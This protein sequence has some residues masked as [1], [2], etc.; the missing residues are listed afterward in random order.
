[1][2]LYEVLGL[3]ERGTGAT[4]EEITKAYR[5]AALKA[6][7]DKGGSK[8]KWERL[9][10]A[11]E[12]LS[13]KRLRVIYDTQGLEAAERELKGE[14]N[15][16]PA[17]A[18]QFFQA[19]MQQHSQPQRSVTPVSVSLKQ[20]YLAEPIDV[21]GAGDK[22]LRITLDNLNPFG[23]GN[24]VF[25][26][27]GQTTIQLCLL[28]HSFL[29][30][31]PRHLVFVQKIDICE[32]L[33]GFSVRFELP[34]NEKTAVSFEYKEKVVGPRTEMELPANEKQKVR[35]GWKF[36]IRFDVVFAAAEN[37]AWKSEKDRQEAKGLLERLLGK[38]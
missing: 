17:W 19:F 15:K 20:I 6:H 1:M 3:K 22:K 33:T 2:S 25:Y 21:E 9:A 38:R 23:A 12:I 30:A 26:T 34:D 27:V 14:N 28:P 10:R 4:D 37:K 16:G 13:N 29:L 7:P 11:Y 24:R 18:Q 36:T 8:E 32:A 5:K 31:G 35:E